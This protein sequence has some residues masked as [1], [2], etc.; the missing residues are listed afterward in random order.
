LSIAKRKPKDKPSS[1]PDKPVL[2]NQSYIYSGSYVN[3]M[4]VKQTYNYNPRT[5]C[6]N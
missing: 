2:E 4:S 5:S 1:S 3:S 6:E